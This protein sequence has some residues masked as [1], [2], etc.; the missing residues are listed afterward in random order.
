MPPRQYSQAAEED[1]EEESERWAEIQSGHAHWVKHF[2]LL[3]WGQS[4]V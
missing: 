2:L 4:K 1:V 3:S